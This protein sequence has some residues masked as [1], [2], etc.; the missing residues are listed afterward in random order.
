MADRVG[1]RRAPASPCTF[2]GLPMA[3]VSTRE[4][5]THRGE[6]AHYACAPGLG[7][8]VFSGWATETVS[9]LVD[10]GGRPEQQDAYAVWTVGPDVVFAVADGMGGH[11][12]GAEAS[13]AALRAWSSLRTPIQAEGPALLGA[14]R[15]H[16][17]VA[18]RAVCAAGDGGTTL[19]LFWVR[20]VRPQAVGPEMR[21]VVHLQVG[22]STGVLVDPAR[23][24]R[25]RSTPQGIGSMLFSCLGRP[26]RT[27]PDPEV[28][29][30]LVPVG[31]L[32]LLY[33][34]G[35]DHGFPERTPAGHPTPAE[36]GAVYWPKGRPV[37]P[38][39]P[40]SL[41]AALADAR[42]AGSTANATAIAWILR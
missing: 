32:L 8:P 28:H 29:A 14:L 36:L 34:D 35:F 10:L 33:T 12:D 19:S 42:A 11:A 15:E 4:M 30:T 2:C 6:V 22:D 18:H 24:L 7:S 41:S 1:V 17:G 31:S 26:N 38:L 16:N 39:S 27:N 9:V 23:R 25:F 21:Q 37:V 40:P 3:M 13:A 20:R 5:V